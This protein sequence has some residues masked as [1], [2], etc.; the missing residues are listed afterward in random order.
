MPF[1]RYI[2]G[3]LGYI[4][5]DGCCWPPQE[6]GRFDGEI[7][8]HNTQLQIAAKPLVLCCHRVNA[9]DGSD[10]TFYP[11]TVVFVTVITG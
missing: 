11:I 2:C 3:V 6:K 8:S 9:N 7:L 4:V 10:S 5:S 1:D